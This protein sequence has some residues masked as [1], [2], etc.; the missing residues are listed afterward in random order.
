MSNKKDNLFIVRDL[1]SIKASKDIPGARITYYNRISE[2]R[3]KVGETITF[4]DDWSRGKFEKGEILGK[5]STPEDGENKWAIIYKPHTW[6]EFAGLHNVVKGK[7]GDKV[8]LNTGS[9]NDGVS[10]LQITPL[11][12]TTRLFSSDLDMKDFENLKTVSINPILRCGKTQNLVQVM[13]RTLQEGWEINSEYAK[14]H[15]IIFNPP[16]STVSETFAKDVST[17]AEDL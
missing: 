3:C 9:F 6:G 13:G 7:I 16:Y 4:V 1:K 15:V 11:F 17:F 8:Y 12:A 5:F 10:G 14:P 2:N